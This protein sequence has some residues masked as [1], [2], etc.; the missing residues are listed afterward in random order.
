MKA[1]ITICCSMMYLC[2]QNL[3]AQLLQI[4]KSEDLNTFISKNEQ[5]PIDKA[6]VLDSLGHLAYS[7]K[8][9]HKADSLF[10]LGLDLKNNKSNTDELDIANSYENLG[11]TKLM[12]QAYSFSLHY[13]NK[14]ISCR[15]KYLEAD[16]ETILKLRKNIGI[17]Y[18]HSEE[19]RE[20]ISNFRKTM[21]F[22]EHKFGKDY[23]E[24]ASLYY[25]HAR[26]LSYNGNTETSI[27]SFKNAINI[28]LANP[29]K[30]LEQ[31]SNIH[32]DLGAIYTNSNQFKKAE[33]HVLLSVEAMIKIKGQTHPRV[34][35]IYNELGKIYTLDEKFNK[36]HSIF[37]KALK[38]NKS[39]YGN[40]APEMAS[41][42]NY[43]GAFHNRSG[44]QIKAKKYFQL[45][46]DIA[47]QTPLTSTKYR[48]LLNSN[49]GSANLYLHNYEQAYL[50]FEKALQLYQKIP[51]AGFDVASTYHRL[52]GVAY[53]LERYDEA[54]RYTQK[55][56][57]YWQKAYGGKDLK[58][59]ASIENI[60][61]AYSKLGK[62]DSSIILLEQS[63]EIKQTHLKE[64][65]TRFLKSQYNLANQYTQAKQFAISDSIWQVIIPTFQKSLKSKYLEMSN[66]QRITYINTVRSISDNFFSFAV[67][68]G[69]PKTKEIATNF[70][71]NTKSLTLDYA[72][73]AQSLIQT[74]DNPILN[75]LQVQLEQI[76]DSISILSSNKDLVM[77]E[78]TELSLREEMDLISSQIHAILNKNSWINNSTNQWQIIQ[79]KLSSEEVSLDFLK[80]FNK[81][82]NLWMYHAILIST[83]STC[84]VFIEL[85]PAKSFNRF[86]NIKQNK[87]P[88]YL[89]TRR[90]R[91]QLY[92]LIWKPIQPYLE[93]IKN[94]HI[95]ATHLFHRLPFE[96]LQNEEYSFLA[97]LYDIRYYTNLR[98]LKKKSPIKN[99]IKDALLFGDISY[100]IASSTTTIDGS[101]RQNNQFGFYELPYTSEEIENISTTCKS[102]GINTMTFTKAAAT[103][104]QLHV[105]T[106]TK[107]PYILHFATH[108]ITDTSLQSN[109]GNQFLSQNNP[110][111]KT[112]ILLSGANDS[113]VAKSTIENDPTDG[114]LTALE[115]ST[116]DLQK[117]NL[118][119]LSACGTG[120]GEVYDSE[121]VFGLQRAFKIAGVDHVLASLWDVNDEATKDLMVAFYKNHLTK[122]QSPALALRNA[123][124]TLREAG[125]EAKDWAGFILTE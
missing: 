5:G 81:Q 19:Y 75:Q 107:A 6:K 54:I 27:T 125:Y 120:L 58:S 28:H 91:Q 30:E 89:L 90:D 55:A 25:W 33:K 29:E 92:Q 97:E 106:K 62:L 76:N 122:D 69:S 32:Y 22:Y 111:Q 117:T 18:Y 50:F 11:N 16:H 4:S 67:Y 123:K 101:S 64:D 114:I 103:E 26:C 43:L 45:A 46:L 59:A 34:A 57:T 1:I 14:A 15:T 83:T 112:A 87:C 9:F 51:N 40:H 8:E 13:Y 21:N 10:S 56:L 53:E 70:L 35:R 80:S 60:G 102:E 124:A 63:L 24:L 79:E 61:L 44:D 110:L 113:W 42:Y 2:M 105:F 52:G 98:D 37:L 82:D 23:L 77:M 116:L 118:V 74:I 48:A 119:V 99:K 36:A 104:A 84:P 121:G 71:L 49:I 65:N 86:L 94:I 88:E 31:L 17:V 38:I 7:E 100:S 41:A 78:Q 108:G 20:A 85:G 96:S 12:L 66:E 47:D 39:V 109:D 3:D 68:H 93:G 72:V 73:S 95:S 115:V